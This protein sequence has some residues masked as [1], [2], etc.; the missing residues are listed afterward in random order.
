MEANGAPKQP[1]YK[2]SLKKSSFVFGRTTEFIQV[3][4]YLKESKW[5]QNFYFICVNY[6]FNSLGYICSNSQKYM[7]QNYKLLFYAQNH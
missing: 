6:P 7:G 2:L 5:W 4:K 1:D 3:W